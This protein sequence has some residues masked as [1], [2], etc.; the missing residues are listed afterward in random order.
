MWRRRKC[1]LGRSA[2]RMCRA[3]SRDGWRRRE[4]ICAVRGGEVGL[5]GGGRARRAVERRCVEIWVKV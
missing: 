3:D 2:F 4:A 5:P 1:A